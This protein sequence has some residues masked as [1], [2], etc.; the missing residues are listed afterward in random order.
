MIPLDIHISKPQ[1]LHAVAMTTAYQAVKNEDAAH[2]YDRVAV[3]RA[4]HSLL[5]TFWRDCCAIV[6]HIL[7]EYCRQPTTC[8]SPSAS[9]D[10][11]FHA[12][13]L[14]PENWDDTQSS[15]VVTSLQAFF[16]A[17]MVE[18]W[19]AL[20]WPEASTNHS[21]QA[22]A[23][24]EQVRLCLEARQRKPRPH[25]HFSKVKNHEKENKDNNSHHPAVEAADDL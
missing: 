7:Q 4:D 11:D 2:L 25:I 22:K 14:M 15:S 10:D 17:Y 20:V 23:H 6:G 3:V 16:V 18:R 1:T 24:Q 12:L 5:E 21:V 8:P 9:Q 19:M 13:L